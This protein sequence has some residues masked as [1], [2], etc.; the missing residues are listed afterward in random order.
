MERRVLIKLPGEQDGRLSVRVLASDGIESLLCA[1][2]A[3]L[4]EEL[5]KGA[6]CL[7]V[8]EEAL[9][10]PVLRVLAGHRA[11]QPAWSDLPV[12]VMAKRG[13]DSLEA[14]RALENLGN[15]TMLE[16]PVRTITLIS[17]ARSA[18]RARDRQYEMRA[19]SRRKDEF[20]ATLAHELRNPLAPIANAMAIMTRMHPTPQVA[21]LIAVVE[22]QVSH[23]KRLVDD[24]LDVARITSGKLD[25]QISA[26]TIARVVTQAMEIAEHAVQVK[27]HRIA[28]SQ[29]AHDVELQADHVRVVQGLANLLVNAA[30]FT[31]PSGEISLTAAVE[32]SDAVFVVRDT[33]RGL[34]EGELERIFDIFEQSRAVGEP[35]GG[36]GLGLHLTRAFAAMHGGSVKARSDGR[37]RGSE[38]TLRLPVVAP[39]SRTGECGSVPDGAAAPMPRTVLVV[40]DNED[41]AATLETL[42]ELQGIAVSVAH[43]GAAALDRVRNDP[44]EVVIMDIGMPVM[45]GYEAAHSI[46]RN[47][48]GRPPVLIAL[49]GW[50]QHADKARAKDAGFDHHLVKPL[51]F[52]E[53]L[54]CLSQYAAN[55]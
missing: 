37:G 8:A 40:D 55:G 5:G 51:K 18:L 48:V 44:P 31:P 30:K 29:P 43:D 36:L 3:E 20:L 33:G 23:L 41:A 27:Q 14:Q 9:T 34:E 53:L 42:L 54:A 17:A 21:P 49:T 25:L 35:T 16:R 50:G 32:G 10:E 22:R 6:G 12:L 45:N 4:Q 46:R 7:L 15:V 28:V 13:A 2:A 39:E 24:L 38:F 47:A 1:T 19:L 52:D 26:T 11:A